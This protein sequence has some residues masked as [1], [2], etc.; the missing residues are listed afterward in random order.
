[1]SAVNDTETERVLARVAKML[2]LANDAA[3]SEGERN[4]AL[5]MAHATLQK[6]NLSLAE[7]E[8]RAGT[9]AA[10]AE[11]RIHRSVELR[12]TWTRRVA[13]AVAYLL[14][15]RCLYLRV[16]RVQRLY[17]VGRESN[18]RTCIMM[19]EYLVNSI[20]REAR[21]AYKRDT[22]MMLMPASVAARLGVSASGFER[23]FAKGAANSISLRCA[24][25]RDEA[26]NGPSNS[27]ALVLYQSED[28]L[29]QHYL[30]K[31]GVEK[32]TAKN[33]ERYPGYG[34]R[35]GYEYGDSI[36]LNKQVE[37]KETKQ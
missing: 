6:H 31:M 14:Y 13:N 29:N 22:G 7:A 37:H 8:E 34:Y 23:S 11:T 12:G 28:Q 30:D 4:N 2:R 36:P 24:K 10:P 19:V 1:M 20:K 25:L 18:V 33:R 32:R 3:A 15:C 9:G 16:G 17:F 5:R 26:E 35:Q 21:A 27:R